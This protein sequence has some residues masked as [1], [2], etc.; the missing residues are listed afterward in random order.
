ML[1]IMA[2]IGWMLVAGAA[3]AVV[4]DPV[5]Q[6]PR[7]RLEPAGLAPIPCAQI[8]DALIAYNERA[9]MADSSVTDWIGATVGVIENWYRKLQPLEGH[10]SQIVPGTFLE[11]QKGAAEFGELNNLVYDNSATLADELDNIIVSLSACRVQE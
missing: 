1:K 10:P 4:L 3:H 8:T 9:R 6:A 7:E 11:I 5:S 2:I